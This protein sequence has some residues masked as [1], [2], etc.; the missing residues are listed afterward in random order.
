[1]QPIINTVNKAKNLW[2]NKI[3]ALREQVLLLFSS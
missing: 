2:L 3:T 1:M